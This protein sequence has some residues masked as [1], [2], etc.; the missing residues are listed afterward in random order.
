VDNG[1]KSKIC[2][3]CGQPILMRHGVK[4]SPMLA[5]LYDAIASRPRIMLEELRGLVYP[6]VAIEQA[7]KR[8]KAQIWHLNEALAV[9]DVYVAHERCGPYTIV[10]LKKT[11]MRRTT[12]EVRRTGGK[13]R[14]PAP[15]TLP[16]VSIGDA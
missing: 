6:G 14:G 15:I 11:G 16:K 2:P 8:L 4:L 7:D 3:H 10:D 12:A 9:S 5:K 13:P 1:H